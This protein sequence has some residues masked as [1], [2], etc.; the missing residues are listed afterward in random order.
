MFVLL[1]DVRYEGQSLL[2]VYSSLER[3]QEAGRSYVERYV[4]EYGFWSED[5]CVAVCDCAL[6][7]EA[8]DAH[9]SSFEWEYRP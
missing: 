4:A 7:A 1:L 3:A 8:R 2:G 6:D 9:Y 5:S